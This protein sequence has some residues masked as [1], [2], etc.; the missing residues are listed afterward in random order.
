MFWNIF[1]SLR[2]PLTKAFDCY[3]VSLPPPCTCTRSRER[4]WRARHSE[5]VGRGTKILLIKQEC[6][7]YSQY[8]GVALPSSHELTEHSAS[9]HQRVNSKEQPLRELCEKLIFKHRR[10]SAQ[11][12]S[13]KT[14][15]GNEARSGRM[16]IR[17]DWM[18]CPSKFTKS[19]AGK[20]N[21]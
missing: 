3:S 14:G 16:E 18:K 10:R 13:G 8:L 7:N 17:P 19:L 11:V 20:R 9:R 6:N 12:A 4:S 5:G 1:E 2:R 21:R 15:N